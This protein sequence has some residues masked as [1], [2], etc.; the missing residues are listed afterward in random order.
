MTRKE[1]IDILEAYKP[2]SNVYN[3]HNSIEEKEEI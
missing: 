1:V 2:S 3:G